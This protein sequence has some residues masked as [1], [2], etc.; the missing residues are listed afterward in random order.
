MRKA[1]AAP[2]HAQSARIEPRPFDRPI[3]VT[4]PYLPPIMEC[5][6]SLQ[7]IWDNQGLTNN[8]PVLKRSRSQLNRYPGTGSVCLFHN[9][10]LALH[11]GLRGR[12]I[13]G[14]VITAPS[15]FVA[16]TCTPP[17]QVQSG[18]RRHRAGLLHH[19]PAEVEAAMTPWT[20]SS[21]SLAVRVSACPATLKNWRI[22]LG[23]CDLGRS[24]IGD[25]G[26]PLQADL[27]H[28]V[29][30]VWIDESAAGCKAASDGGPLGSCLVI[31]M[32]ASAEAMVRFRS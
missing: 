13:A 2:T 17:G 29:L 25:D 31:T 5:C 14:E 3:C 28:P 24:R 1:D 23:G 8:G 16:A 18:V 15:T 20:W 22:G 12:G 30:R 7:E 10:T 11:L 19:G 27:R 9:G 21:V 4:R 26:I 6:G 32:L